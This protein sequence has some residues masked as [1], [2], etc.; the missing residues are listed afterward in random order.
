MIP[1]ARTPRLA[2]VCDL[3]EEGWPSMDLVAEMLLGSLER[4]H[5]ESVAARR[6]RPPLRRRFTAAS[7]GSAHLNGG[8]EEGRFRVN[9]D[10]VLNRFW[11]YPRLLRRSQGD[12]DLFHL[13]DHSYGQLVHHLPAERT[14]VTCHDLHTFQCLLA[15]EGHP[16]S[17]PFRMMT[18]HILRGVARAARVVFDTGAVRDEA[19]A[20]GL[21]DPERAT[22]AHLGVHPACTPEAD[23]EADAEAARL[24]GRIPAGAP[25]LLHVGGTYGRK[26]IDL[27]LRIFAG[28][29]RELPDAWL[30]RVGGPFSAEQARLADQ[31]GVADAIEVLPF[32][33]RRVLS[34][35][36]RRAALVVLP[37]EEEGFGL[38][39]LEAMTCGTPVVASDLPVL[40]EVGGDAA[41]YQS[42]GDVAGWSDAVVDLLSERRSD[43][44]AWEA[45]RAAG[46]ARAERFTW[47]EYAGKMVSVYQG[48]LEQ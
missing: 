17:T 3:L 32:V 19:L 12:F 18:R 16:R 37:S 40:K 6:V 28:V 31:L 10:R 13:V 4:D 11:D 48:V 2:L 45:R 24:L 33:E 1:P 41:E 7:N 38:P 42:V 46:L 23:P 22:V 35:V 29:R 15:P 43:P 27:L 5:P 26:R 47:R 20:H 25:C 30:V 21:V 14:V 9:A 39:V 36:Y 44:A 8:A 34:A